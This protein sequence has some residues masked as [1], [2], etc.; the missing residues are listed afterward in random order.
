MKNLYIFPTKGQSK[1]HLAHQKQWI[2]SV[3]PTGKSA[4]YNSY[5]HY[6]YITSDEKYISPTDS[7]IT[8]EGKLSEVR[9]ES[10]KGLEG[11]RKITYSNDPLL[12]QKGVNEIPDAFLEKFIAKPTIQIVEMEYLES[13]DYL[14]SKS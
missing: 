1:L 9:F 13:L 4:L 2:M 8:K 10:E 6:M 11:T 14:S 3:V 5:P 12:L 7:L